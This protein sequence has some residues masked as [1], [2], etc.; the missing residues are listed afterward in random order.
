MEE[1]SDVSSH[2]AL[3][4]YLFRKMPASVNVKLTCWLVAEIIP[5]LFHVG[6]GKLYGETLPPKCIYSQCL[7][8]GVNFQFLFDL[9]NI[10]IL[11][12][13]FLIKSPLFSLTNFCSLSEPHP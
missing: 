2:K 9:L 10:L 5:D 11:N 3:H 8:A 6:E 12:K 13:T 4:S 7:T 1:K